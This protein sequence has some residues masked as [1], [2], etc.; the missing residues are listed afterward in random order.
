MTDL[1][2]LWAARRA[3]QCELEAEHPSGCLYLTPLESKEA[4]TTSGL[5]VEVNTE[6]AARLI[7]SGGFRISTSE[8]ISAF[9][10]HSARQRRAGEAQEA[11]NAGRVTLT[12]NL[13][14]DAPRPAPGGRKG[15]AKDQAA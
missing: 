13:V 11:R 9:H 6:N 8:E 10:E 2:A 1:K 4:N 15:T 5:A 14:V 3:K 7:L 12:L